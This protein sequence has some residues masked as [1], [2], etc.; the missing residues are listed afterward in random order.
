[1]NG[2]PVWNSNSSKK[3][4]I[5]EI[6]PAIAHAQITEM[7]IL[8][9]CGNIARVSLMHSLLKQAKFLPYVDMPMRFNYYL[10]YLM[11]NLFAY[12]LFF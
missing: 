1:M 4:T 2:I 10:F 9:L 11:F 3:V 8:H 12:L 7:N 6:D 5:V